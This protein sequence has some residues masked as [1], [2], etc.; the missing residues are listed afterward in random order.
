MKKIWFSIIVPIY[1]CENYLKKN[2]ESI[3]NQSYKHFELILINDGSTDNSLDIINSFTDKRIVVINKKNTGVSDTRNVGIKNSKYDY[4]C[5]FDSDDYIEKDTLNNYVY[6]INKYNPDMVLCGFFSEVNNKKDLLYFDEKYYSNKNMIKDDLVQLYSKHM[7][8]NVWNKVYKKE[9]IINNDI[10][11]PKTNWGEDRQFNQDYLKSINTMY[12]TDK[13][14]YHYVR[15]RKDSITNKYYD[16]LF[17]IRI[18]ECINLIYFFNYFKINKTDYINF[19]SA[20][21]IERSLGCIDNIISTKDSFKNNYNLIKK[22]IY[23]DQTREY[24]K[25]YIPKSLKMKILVIPIKY[26]LVFLAYVFGFIIHFIRSKF[27]G[28]FNNLKNKR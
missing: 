6:I 28:V 3:L 14:L 13:C 10:K 9:I 5:F 8:Y 19:I 21:F 11:F 24:L 4:I 25:Y 7:L 17:E 1:N 20:N 23:H 2:I 12:C 15:E 22:I 18:N 27:P 16:N 26:K